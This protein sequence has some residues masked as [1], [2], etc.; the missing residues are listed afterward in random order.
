MNILILGAAGML[1]HKMFQRLRQRYPDTHATLRG[2]INDGALA[3]VELFRRGNV[4]EHV[5]ADDLTRLIRLLR[6]KRPQVIINCV[7]LIKQRAAAKEVAPSITLNAL[8]PHQLAEICREWD[9]RLIHFSTDCVFSG[10]T[11]GYTEED[12]SD[13]EDLYGKTKYLGEVTAENAVTLRT[14]IIGRELTQHASLLEWFLSQNHK[15]VRG[16]QRAMY[17]GVTTNQLVDVV[18][19]IIANFPRLSGIYQ[20]TSQTISKYDLLCLLRDA[21]S[22]DIE[23]LPDSSFFCDRSMWGGKFHRATGYICPSW[24]ELVAE[25][26]H[27]A[28]PY[29]QWRSQACSYS[30]VNAF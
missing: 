3:K 22:L 15:K 20:V 29:E 21:Y 7:G 5:Q 4:I 19:D 1:G 25:L 11:G 9:G 30:K 28:T 2:S 14:S 16:Y 8:L 6:G 24:P 27:D 10:K 17:S 18:A 13:A 26:A 12:V 23:I